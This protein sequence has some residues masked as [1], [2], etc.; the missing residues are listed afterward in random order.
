MCTHSDSHREQATDDPI[1]RVL[2]NTFG[3]GGSIESVI[4]IGYPAAE[5]IF[6]CNYE[7]E[8]LIVDLCHEI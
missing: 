7:V 4:N 5:K 1:Y 6:F 8:V 2:N 3:H